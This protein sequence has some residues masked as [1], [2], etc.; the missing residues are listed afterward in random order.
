[1]LTVEVSV[2]IY[3]IG[4]N[5]LGLRVSWR[6]SFVGAG[7]SVETVRNTVFLDVGNYLQ[8]GVLDEHG[9]TSA[10]GGTAAIL[11]RRPALVYE[12]LL[13]PWIARHEDGEHLAGRCVVFNIVTH[14]NPD[15]DAIISAYLVRHLVERGEFPEDASALASYCR[16]VDL[17]HYQVD[18]SN[19]KTATQPIHMGILAMQSCLEDASLMEQGLR[20]VE[21]SLDDIRTARTQLGLGPASHLSDFFA[22]CPGVDRWRTKSEWLEFAHLVDADYEKYASQRASAE[23]TEVR[24]PS[25][26][27]CEE[28]AVPTLILRSQPTSVLTKYWV[29]SEGVCYFICPYQPSDGREGYFRRVIISLDPLW[30]CP[31]TGRK[32]TL[33]GLGY[34]LEQ[35]EAEI[36]LLDNG[37][38]YRSGEPRFG[39]GYSDNDDPWYD[40]RAFDYTIV[41]SPRCGTELSLSEVVNIASSSFWETSI[42]AGSFFLIKSDAEDPSVQMESVVGSHGLS[43]NLDAFFSDCKL[44]RLDST[45]VG[46]H[47]QF[48]STF[49]VSHLAL[50]KAFNSRF[51][52]FKFDVKP[53][54]TLPQL[55]EWL[56]AQHSKPGESS[57]VCRIPVLGG[58]MTLDSRASNREVLFRRLGTLFGYPCDNEAFNLVEPISFVGSWRA[59]HSNAMCVDRLC[60][61]ALYVEALDQMLNRFCR[62]ISVSV[63]R[64]GAIEGA[65]LIQRRFL[66][67]QTRYLQREVSSVVTEQRVF[68][69]LVDTTGVLREYELVKDQVQNLGQLKEQESDA[70]QN[71]LLFLLGLFGVSGFMHDMPIYREWNRAPDNPLEWTVLA[72][73]LLL[74]FGALLFGVRFYRSR[75]KE[76]DIDDREL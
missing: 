72:V 24:L 47:A 41:D 53:G 16:H 68:D 29:R 57:D 6:F 65:S 50:P 23:V 35:R 4:A 63:T 12:H 75:I 19:V 30:V 48:F 14:T 49:E 36:R 51:R 18:K 45:S 60:W 33:E 10:L 74:F 26:D 69:A 40:G 42:L 1:M 76:R 56:S 32:P 52:V 37:M 8:A 64:Q 31:V 54:T 58:V 66:T 55:I 5:E 46:P 27:G 44:G 21:S 59:S 20:F 70:Q 38:D 15:F 13:S 2:G 62:R 11:M 22:G 25:K 28:L 39:D 9:E 67:F 71:V 17:G 7:T 34:S 43:S 73:F 61:I 3:R